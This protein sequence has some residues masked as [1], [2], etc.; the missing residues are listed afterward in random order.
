VL[1]G[2]KFKFHLQDVKNPDSLTWEERKTQRLTLEEGA[3]NSDHY[4]CNLFETE[5]IE[6]M[7]TSKSIWSRG[8]ISDKNAVM[9]AL[10][11]YVVC[12]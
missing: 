7:W 1:N 3:F 10:N 9:C 6:Y 5:D 4:L 8:K 11:R 2:V 12:I